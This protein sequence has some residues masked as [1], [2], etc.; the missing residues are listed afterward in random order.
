[1]GDPGWH[2]AGLR[3]QSHAAYYFYQC[4]RQKY[5][6]KL[7]RS[8]DHKKPKNI[9]IILDDRNSVKKF[10]TESNNGSNLIVSNQ[11]LIGKIEELHLDLNI[12]LHRY[13]I[14]G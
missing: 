8:E 9:I 6:G 14:K 3:L 1:M 2:Y 5:R 12:Q 13:K 7:L 11:K 10:W 4:Y